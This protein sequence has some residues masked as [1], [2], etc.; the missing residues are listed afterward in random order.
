[1][2]GVFLSGLAECS[3]ISKNCF[4]SDLRIFTRKIYSFFCPIIAGYATPKEI[5]RFQEKT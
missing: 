2:F 3:A 4:A 5:E 1:M